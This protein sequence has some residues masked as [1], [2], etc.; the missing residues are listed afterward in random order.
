MNYSRRKI[1]SNADRYNEPQ[2]E[3]TEAEELE[4][5]IDRQ[6]MAFR[7][8]LKDADQ[9]K[10]FDPAAYFRFKSEK[11]VESQDPIEESQQARKL[12]EIRLDDI[13]EALMT[14]P[15]QDRLCLRD[16][17]VKALDRDTLG[18]VSLSTGKPIVPKLVRGQAASDI[19]IKPSTMTTRATT[20]HSNTTSSFTAMDDDL[21]ELLDFTK[22]YGTPRA[23]TSAVLV[24]PIPSSSSVASP[25][26]SVASGSSKIRLPPLLSKGL[27][28]TEG[29]GASPATRGLPPPT[30]GQ[31]RPA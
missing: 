23:S 7:E 27:K 20:S 19:L 30:K 3:V 31:N 8:L 26:A 11:E 13:G 14:L 4:Q 24:S 17:D 5:G 29:S 22:T 1:V 12:L 16:S 18:K 28:P 10:T 15:I 25:I 9:K 2:E 6:T 21:D